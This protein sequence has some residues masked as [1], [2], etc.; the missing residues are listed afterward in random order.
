MA[1]GWVINELPKWIVLGAYM[2][3]NIALFLYQ[4][5]LFQDSDRFYY[6]RIRTREALAFARGPSLPI[7]FNVILILLPVCRNLISFIRGT[8]RCPPRTVRRILDKNLTFHKAIAWVIIASSAMHVI[9]HWYNYERLVSLANNN[10]P[11]GPRRLNQQWPWEK[12]NVPTEAQ[13]NLASVQIDPITICFTTAAGITGHIITVALFLM[14]TSSFDFIRRSYFEVFWYTHHLFIVFLLGLAF[15]QFQELL[16]LQNNSPDLSSSNIHDPKFCGVI[17]DTYEGH[18]TRMSA[19]NNTIILDNGTTL[20]SGAS[21]SAAAPCSWKYMLGGLIIYIIERIIRFIRSLRNV[22]IVKVVEHPSK[23]FEIQMRRKG[24]FAEAGQYVFINV[25]SVA[26]LEWHPFTLTSAPEED[27][28]S[29]HIRIVGDWTEKVAKQLGVG[30][31]DFQQAWELPTISVDGPFGTASEDVFSH[32]VGLLVGAGIGVTPFAS[33]LKSVFYK[34]TQEDTALKLRKVYFYWICPEPSAFE[35]FA[36][37]L[38]SVESQMASKGISDFLD[39][40]IYL[41]RG[42]Q[43]SQAFSIMLQEGD[44]RD[45][46]TGLQAKTHF[47]RPDWNKEFDSI[48]QAHPNTSVGVFF[49]GPSVLSHNL[50][51]YCNEYTKSG[52]TTR[53]R[54]YFNKENF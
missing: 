34:L 29:V 25:P 17:G 2:L 10:A 35:W 28:F 50:H 37:L 4:F 54:F 44:D 6:M 19:N 39:T 36:D 13:P 11:Q 47:G 42:W 21:F 30:R 12:R 40:H 8:G 48:S 7:N 15:H 5:F 26:F 1:S 53:A 14:V 41:T 32:E 52:D 27:Y 38:Q 22:V 33:I 20:C 9:A 49:C 24:F 23:T 43:D 18:T 51:R 16:P 31:G 3:I 45:A 46:I